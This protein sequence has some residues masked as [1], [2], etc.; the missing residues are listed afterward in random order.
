MVWHIKDMPVDFCGKVLI[1]ILS[2]SDCRQSHL[3]FLI[4]K[5]W[6][7]KKINVSE[8]TLKQ[9]LVEKCITSAKLLQRFIE[10]G[11]SLNKD[12][13]VMTMNC[14]QQN[15]LH[16]F[17]F[18]AANS[19][20]QYLGELYHVATMSAHRMTFI[21]IFIELGA[22]IP[23]RHVEELLVCTLK[24]EGNCGALTLARKFT[25]ASVENVY[26]T[27][28]LKTE[29]ANYPLL[30][31]A[32]L[33]CGVDP[34]KSGGGNTPIA[35][36]MDKDIG[37]SE[38]IKLVCLLLD[39]KEHCSH[40]SHTGSKYSTTPLHVATEVALISGKNFTEMYKLSVTTSY[41][42]MR[43]LAVLCDKYSNVSDLL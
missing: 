20:P 41:Y 19:N 26:L 11:L 39:N 6:K 27:S 37:W 24:T 17:K 15:Q 38:K 23:P 21:L 7:D 36:V 9:L 43:K 32:L 4:R 2:R 33:D 5:M 31:K 13:I 29:V 3:E 14:L 30:I 40:L 42:N 22:K 34:N 10:L 16:L 1:E 12:D 28:L 25:K 8:V 35:T 18:I